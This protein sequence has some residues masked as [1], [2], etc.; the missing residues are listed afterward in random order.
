MLCLRVSSQMF[1]FLSVLLTDRKRWR[2]T[3]K[4]LEKERE[5]QMIQ[6]ETGDGRMGE[7]KDE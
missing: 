7:K 3:M 4:R 5:R 6:K 2:E 1:V